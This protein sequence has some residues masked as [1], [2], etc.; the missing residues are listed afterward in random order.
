[1]RLSFSVCSV[2]VGVVKVLPGEV[3]LQCHH[4]PPTLL[5]LRPL[6]SLHAQMLFVLLLGDYYYGSVLVA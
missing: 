2:D 3:L 4:L 1:M 6:P 5:R